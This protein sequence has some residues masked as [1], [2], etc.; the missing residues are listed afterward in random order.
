[1][2]TAPT[3]NDPQHPS[4]PPAPPG[5]V[6][7]RKKSHKLRWTLLG[8]TGGIVAI[9]AIV[10]AAGGGTAKT[11]TPATPTNNQSP[12]VSR[13]IGSQDA[14]G[15]VKLGSYTTD[16]IKVGHVAVTVTNHSSKRSDYVITVALESADGHTQYDTADVYVQNLEPGQTTSQGGMFVNTST[17]PPPTAKLVIQSVE[18]T[19]SL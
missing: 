12:G 16:A 6:P 5:P 2:T 11:T 3:Q 10:S 19:A 15:D 8:L 18:R 7:P 4:A 17:N 1:M 14:T 13:G 9:I